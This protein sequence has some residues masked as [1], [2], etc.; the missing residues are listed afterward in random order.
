MNRIVLGVVV[1]AAIAVALTPLAGALARRAGVVDRP[2]ALKPQA[3]PVAY[4]GGAAVAVAAAGPALAGG[5]GWLLLGPAAALV[6]GLA[7]DC[8]E[9]SPG[10]RLAAEAVV[11]ILV[12]V[13]L[14]LFTRPLLGLC[15]VVVT[16]ALV[17][18]TNVI[19]GLDG[20]AGGVGTAATLGFAV[21]LTGTDRSLGAAVAGAL[22]GFLVYNR[23]PARIYL[24]DA[25]SYF[26]GAVLAELLVAGWARSPAPAATAGLLLVAYPGGELVCSVV[27]RRRARLPLMRGDRDHSYD[28]LVR[29]GLS[30]GLTSLV[31]TGGQALL[32]CAAVAASRL[33]TAAAVIV[34]G[35]VALVLCAGAAAVGLLG[36]AP[37]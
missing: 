24:G 3:R 14:G 36:P 8:L 16:V 20:L 29:R 33:D 28:R 21:V 5:A 15:G 26:L 7:D 13:G 22:L 32:A 35:S 12:S 31:C 18:G 27:R 17:N 30:V 34:V 1:G 2:G 25:G 9:L 23:S 10:L 4:F 37:A 11:G 6:L 19:D